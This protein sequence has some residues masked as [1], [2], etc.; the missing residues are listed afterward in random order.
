ML[1]SHQRRQASRQLSVATEGTVSEGA[2]YYCADHD[3]SNG[4][5]LGRSL[6]GV[7]SD[8]MG[9]EVIRVDRQRCCFMYE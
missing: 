2:Y 3:D 9:Q 8:R 1:A 4:G 5:A 6:Q 7:P